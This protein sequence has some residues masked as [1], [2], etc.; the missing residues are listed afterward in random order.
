MINETFLPKVTFIIK[1]F[2]KIVKYLP[3]RFLAM[4]LSSM[5]IENINLKG[6]KKNKKI[7][8][9]ERIDTAIARFNI[10]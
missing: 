4:T 8:G 9:K 5:H 1:S 6:Q 10:I 2:K 3:I 7:E